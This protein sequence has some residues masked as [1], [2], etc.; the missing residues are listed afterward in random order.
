MNNDTVTVTAGKHDFELIGTVSSS[1]VLSG[2]KEVEL[3]SSGVLSFELVISEIAASYSR[4]NFEITYPLGTTLADTVSKIEIQYYKYDSLS[5]RGVPAS[6]DFDNCETYT[7]N[8]T[9]TAQATSEEGVTTW[10][11][12]SLS[13]LPTGKY[14]F[15]INF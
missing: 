9:S 5:A 11:D 13:P 14:L 12:S 1:L 7:T 6:E 3:T 2:T 4:A 15:R 10:K 8:T